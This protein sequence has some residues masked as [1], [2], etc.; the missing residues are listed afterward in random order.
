VPEPDHPY[1]FDD[2]AEFLCKGGPPNQ[3]LAQHFRRWA[4]PMED[5][6]IAFVKTG[7]GLH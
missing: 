2:V 6:P 7:L 4:R 1:T 3:K 5:Y